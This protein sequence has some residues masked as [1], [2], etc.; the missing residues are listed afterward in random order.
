MIHDHPFLGVGIGNFK[1]TAALYHPAGAQAYIAHDAYLEMAAELGVIGL[2]TFCAMLF[3]TYRTLERV[4]RRAAAVQAQTVFL[5]AQGLQAALVAYMVSMFFL[6]AEYE[7]LFWLM[8][9]LTMSLP[10]ILAQ[11]ETSKAT[12]KSADPRP[13]TRAPISL[14]AVTTAD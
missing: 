6:S 2:L 1:P 12:Q 3:S 4:R 7:K 9:F 8:L 10:G 13:F 5:T 14:E 11:W